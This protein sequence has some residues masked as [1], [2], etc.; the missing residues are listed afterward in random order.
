MNKVENLLAKKILEEIDEAVIK[1]RKVGLIATELAEKT[2]EK[3]AKING[4]L[5]E[6]KGAQKLVES[7]FGKIRVYS[8]REMV[9]LYINKRK[10][11]K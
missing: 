9:D 10:R 8:P 1:N 4:M 2:D 7:R 3:V 11:G 5:R 6:L